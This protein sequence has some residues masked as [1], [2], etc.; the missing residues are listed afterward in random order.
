[1]RRDYWSYAALVAILVVAA[2][3]RFSG[4]D[5]D[6]GYL[7][8]PDERKILLVASEIRLPSSVPEFF[9][10]DSP[11]NPKFF[12]YGSFPIY[13]LKALSV[14]APAVKYT[15]P[16]S[17]S[18]LVGLALLGRALS[19]LFDLG[20]AALTFLLARRLYSARVGWV[21]AA[22]MAVT[23]LHIQLSHFYAVDTLL[24]F[25]VVATVFFAARFA[26]TAKRGDAILMGVAFGLAMATKISAAPLVA[27]MVFAVVHVSCHPELRSGEGSRSGANEMLRFAQHDRLK[28]VCHTWLAR[29][30]D[31]RRALAGI[32]GVALGVFILTQ[33]YALL[34]PIRYFGQIG[35]E[36]LVARGWLDYPY[37][38]QFADGLPFIYQIVQSSIWGLSLPLGV[39]AWGGA[40]FFVWQWWRR[41]DWQSGLVLSWA[42]VYF[43]IVGGQYAK[44]PRYLLPLVPFLFLMAGAAFKHYVSRNT[45]HVLR[46]A[47]SIGLLVILLSAFL[48]SLAFSS[49]YSREHPWLQISNWIYQNVP[50]GSAVAVEHW[51][52]LLPLAIR[53][54]G[55]NRNPTEYRVQTLP[56]YD[57][58]DAAKVQTLADGL[59]G[60]DYIVLA[61][62]R[63]YA[64][65]ARLPQ[66][67]P[68]SS[69]YYRL[70]F[71]GQLGFE[72]AAFARND[73]NVGGLTIADDPVSSIG[74]PA[75]PALLGYWRRPG[76]WVWGHADESFIVY[77]HPM[78]LVFKKTRALSSAQILQL[79]TTP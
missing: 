10:S 42:L 37:T 16:W 62:P 69:R 63:L 7:F 77:D 28:R 23:V 60:S 2:F 33:P 58:D 35:T 30:W 70:L 20:T 17:D 66:R 39:L 15:V 48:Y 57:A 46:I 64:T 40:A 1:V 36:S 52:D 53:A 54:T 31:T 21:A 79:L 25:F 55:A 8:H 12:A 71:G 34:D 24:A 72:L 9:S 67:Y 6:R 27:P 65:I 76:V 38:R 11:L 29:I 68:I 5:W 61:S 22:C 74:L 3:F 50:A 43:L 47:C 78:P 44:Y 59:A 26:E 14:F 4:L 41:R 73:P 75:P 13:L 45:Q 51:D 19:G 49:I 32:F 56:M 18:N